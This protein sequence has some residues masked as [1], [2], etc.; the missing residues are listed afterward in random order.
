MTRP[1]KVISMSSAATHVQVPHVTI[2]VFE[3]VIK[4]LE[5]HVPP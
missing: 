5:I 2:A 1:R 3:E 4:L